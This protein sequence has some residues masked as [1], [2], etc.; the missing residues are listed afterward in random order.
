MPSVEGMAT[1]WP[2]SD[3][4]TCNRLKGRAPRHSLWHV[5]ACIAF[6]AI[7]HGSDKGRFGKH[8]VIGSPIS[9]CFS[10]LKMN[11]SLMIFILYL[12]IGTEFWAA[13]Y[14]RRDEQRP[15]FRGRP[16]RLQRREKGRPTTGRVLPGGGEGVAG[17]SSGSYSRLRGQAGGGRDPGGFRA[18]TPQNRIVPVDA[19]PFIWGVST[20]PVRA[21][22]REEMRNLK[23]IRS[24]NGFGCVLTAFLAS[25]KSQPP[26]ILF[27]WPIRLI[28]FRGRSRALTA[29]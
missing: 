1:A 9:G 19:A 4:N 23:R 15:D 10:V 16:G 13:L 24:K 25:K 28:L 6:M 21:A 20:E 11:I 29:F 12:K 3:N 27:L 5:L 14:M 26:G 22:R 17:A 8:H 7:F 18:R 2:P